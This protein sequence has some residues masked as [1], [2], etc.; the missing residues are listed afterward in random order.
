L[1]ISAHALRARYA[2]PAQRPLIIWIFEKRL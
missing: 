1:L 2:H